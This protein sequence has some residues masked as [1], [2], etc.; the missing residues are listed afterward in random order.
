MCPACGAPMA[1]DELV[2]L[3]CRRTRE[4]SAAVQQAALPPDAPVAHA[5]PCSKHP[6]LPVAGACP[7]CGAFVCIRCAPGAASGVLTCGDCLRREQEKYAV[8]PSAFGGPLVLPLI[9]LVLK[10]V[11]F[12]VVFIAALATGA[13]RIG[14]MVA[15]SL[16]LTAP[17]FV[18][19]LLRKR[20][21]PFLLVAVYVLD[22]TLAVLAGQLFPA[23][24][25]GWSLGWSVYFL[26]S[27]RVKQTFTR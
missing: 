16:L 11:V 9:G 20:W 27:R 22:G 3:T 1:A 24:W 6:A 14:L 19:F 12:F 18:G 25:V 15:T 4:S 5:E 7:R 2:C 23:A 8:K 13:S 21:V 26:L 10:S 17:A